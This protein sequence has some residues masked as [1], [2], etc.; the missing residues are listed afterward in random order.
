[1]QLV[2]VEWDGTLS[3]KWC[4]S[5][6]NHPPLQLPAGK[7]A[8]SRPALVVCPGG[9]APGGGH[10]RSVSLLH[11]ALWPALR[12]GQLPQVAHLHGC[13]LCGEC[14]CHPALE[15]QD[16]YVSALLSCLHFPSC[17]LPHP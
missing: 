6:H 9:L 12:T 2:G 8:P 3:P 7:Q 4:H 11:H 1:M 10:Q 5:D 16:P 15:G 14:V 17:Q 13:L